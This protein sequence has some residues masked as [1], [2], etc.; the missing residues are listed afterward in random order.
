MSKELLEYIVK[1]F[2]RLEA[3]VDRLNQDKSFLI[4]AAM[5]VSTLFSIV[6]T[7]IILA[8]KS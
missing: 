3:K 7:L 4:G 8:F 6:T 1:R 2:D 5:G